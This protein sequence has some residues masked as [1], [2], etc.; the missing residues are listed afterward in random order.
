MNFAYYYRKE[1]LLGR[2]QLGAFIIGGWKYV[3]ADPD[4]MVFGGCLVAMGLLLV[5]H[6]G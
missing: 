1:Q 6:L 4:R 5:T 2:T 3:M